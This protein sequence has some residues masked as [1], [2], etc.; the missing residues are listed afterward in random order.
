MSRAGPD[1]RRSPLRRLLRVLAASVAGVVL[2]L[3]VA[4]LLLLA[5]LRHQAKRG[6]PVPAGQVSAARRAEARIPKAPE[7]ATRILFGDLHVHTE[8]SADAR[9]FGLPLFDGEGAHPPA[10]AC[11]FARFCS[12]L[13]FWSINDHAEQMLPEQ[14][15]ETRRSIR[16]CNEAAGPG[17]PDTVAFLGFEWSQ[18]GFRPETHYGHRNV[19]FRDTADEATPTRP[20]AASAVNPWA[21]IGG[22][23]SLAHGGGPGTYA[24]YHRYLYE[25]LMAARCPEEVPVRELPPDCLDVAATPR[26][27]FAKLDDWGFPSL[28]IPHGLAWGV[29]NPAGATLDHQLGAMHDPDRQ[30]LLEVYSGHGNSEVWRDVRHVEIDASGRPQCPEPRGGFT[31]C[32]WRAG[33][34]ARERCDDPGSEA[35]AER[36]ATARAEAFGGLPVG[37]TGQRLEGTRPED[38]LDCGQLQD[39]FLPAFSYRP[40]QSAQY[41]LALRDADAET[42]RDRFR[43]GLI[44]SSDNHRARPGAGY[45]EFGLAA[46]SDG[47]RPVPAWARDGSGMGARLVRVMTTPARGDAF[48]YTGGLVAVHATARSRE[49]IFDAL[50]RR[51]VYGTSGPR[52]QLWFDALDAE[53]RSHPMGSELPAAPEL[54]FRVRA[55][56]AQEERPGCPASVRERLGAAR[57]TSLCLDECHDPSERRIPLDRIEVVRIRP[58]LAPAEAIEDPWRV[59]PCA[60]DEEGCQVEFADPEPPSG[61]HL[62]YVRAIQVPTEAINGDPLSCERDAEG[63]CLRAELCV[64]EG[65]DAPV[66]DACRAPVGERAWSSPIFV[67]AGAAS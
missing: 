57:T 48:Y 64:A 55:S 65:F 41:A 1:R 38:W 24:D 33:E 7:G 58:G 6:E 2:L 61:D 8:Y 35:C 15:E 22:V 5:G 42:G 20:I 67:D 40:Q 47:N 17:E 9:V 30:T 16:A 43:L 59:F 66:P 53:G 3:A 34:I 37:A 36:V 49:A 21:W 56:G 26:D 23:M 44:G 12:A 25:G 62:Y 60:H 27:L 18:T 46:M 63:R 10:D 52:I 28:V 14:W 51:E 45:K 39:A 50:A 32:C 19:I 54:R 11:D 13:D 4:A 29:T 31:P